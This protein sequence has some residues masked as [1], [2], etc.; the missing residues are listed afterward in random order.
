MPGRVPGRLPPER[1]ASAFGPRAPV[2][3]GNTLMMLTAGYWYW[4]AG[5]GAVVYAV[6]YLVPRVI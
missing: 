3:W 6:G 4:T 1:P 5:I 2:W